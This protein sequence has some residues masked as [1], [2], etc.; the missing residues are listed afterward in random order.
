MNSVFF[1]RQI[2][3]TPSLQVE[4]LKKHANNFLR[5]NNINDLTH[6]GPEAI[7]WFLDRAN[8]LFRRNYPEASADTELQLSYFSV[9]CRAEH[10]EEHQA[11]PVYDFLKVELLPSGK[12]GYGVMFSSQM[13]EYYRDRLENGLDTSQIPVD[14]A[15]FRSIFK[16]DSPST[17]VLESYPIIMIPRSS[18]GNG[19]SLTHIYLSSLGLDSTHFQPNS[20]A[21]PFRFYFK[22]D[23][24]QQDDE[25]V[26]A[27][28]A[29]GQAMFEIVRPHLYPLEHEEKP[30]FN[31]ETLSD[32]K[33]E[34][35]KTARKWVADHQ[36]CVDK[37]ISL[38]GIN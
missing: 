29:F 20:S 34:Q 19:P 2:A 14:K 24:A 12:S 26:A 35:H 21:Y 8:T 33:W 10:E 31:M 23:I 28:A 16:Q 18:S 15:F 27:I 4:D 13:R 1:T 38:H 32:V 6:S 25:V 5:Y 30:N 9:F 22:E 17:G 37:L 11:L 36:H 7:Q 3:I